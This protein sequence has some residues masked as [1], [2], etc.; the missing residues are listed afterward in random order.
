MR[1]ISSYDFLAGEAKYVVDHMG[2][3]VTMPANFLDKRDVV[4]E[5]LDFDIAWLLRASRLIKVLEALHRV[6]EQD[7]HAVLPLPILMQRILDWIHTAPAEVMEG[8]R[9]EGMK[10]LHSPT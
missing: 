9:S 1:L 2:H 8:R 4:N 3:I 5:S 10:M 7:V 6:L